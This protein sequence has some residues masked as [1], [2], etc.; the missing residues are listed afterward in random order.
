MRS[1]SVATRLFGNIFLLEKQKGQIESEIG[2]TLEWEE[3]PDGQDSRV[4]RYLDGRYGLAAPAQMVGQDINE[5]HRALAL[6]IKAL[7][8]EDDSESLP[9]EAAA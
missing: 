1:R 3:L 2:Y 5:L 9:A 4:A 6:R 7:Q 8:A